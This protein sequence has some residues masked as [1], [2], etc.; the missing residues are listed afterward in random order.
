MCV[1]KGE[2]GY[3]TANM[4]DNQLILSLVQ[5]SIILGLCLFQVWRLD[6][7]AAF[8]RLLPENLAL[9]LV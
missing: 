7:G 9:V 6:L 5:L 4:Q 1:S 8:A 3:G 2:K